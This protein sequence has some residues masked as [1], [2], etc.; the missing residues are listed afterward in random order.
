MENRLRLISLLQ[1][2][3]SHIIDAT[4]PIVK[5]LQLKIKD[6]WLRYR[7]MKGQIVIYGKPGHD[8]VVGLL[9]QTKNE[10]IL[11]SGP[12]D[13]AKIDFTRPVALF[14]QTTM[15]ISNYHNIA[16]QIR[17]EMIR[18]G[19]SDTDNYLKVYNTI[20]GQVSGREP[21]LQDFCPKT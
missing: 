18:A 17:A 19:I 3:I 4:C 21:H 20:C 15:S 9:G 7:E 1:K 8:E 16:E 10:G 14:S 2:T 13:L 6:S 5:K 11:I 12:D